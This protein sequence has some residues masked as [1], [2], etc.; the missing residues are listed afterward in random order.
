MDHD[1][2]CWP[3]FAGQLEL[4]LRRKDPYISRQ[5]S[6]SAES[7]SFS[8]VIGVQD[9]DDV[10]DSHHHEN[11]PEN[12]RKGAHQVLFAG[13]TG[14]CGRVDIKRAGSNV[15]VDDTN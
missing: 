11:C 12:E 9:D 2:R 14:K 15:T 1:W 4:N 3:S 8:F 7:A 6:I 5:Q 13:R 10:L